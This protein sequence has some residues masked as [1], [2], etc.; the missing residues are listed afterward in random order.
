MKHKASKNPSLNDPRN[1][2]LNTVLEVLKPGRD[3][4]MVLDRSLDPALA[5]RDRALITELVYGYLRYKGRLDYV[6]ESFLKSPGKLPGGLKILMGLAAYEIYFLDRIPDYAA[7][8]RAVAL[9][10]KR[11]GS[12]MSS[13]VNAVLR[14]CPGVDAFDPDF[15]RRDKPGDIIFLSR[16]YSS[17]EWIVQMWRKDYGADIARKYLKQSLQKPATGIRLAPGADAG[18]LDASYVVQR[19]GPSVLVRDHYPGLEDLEREKKVFRQSFAGQKTLWELGLGAWRSPVWD[20]CA[21][22]G[23]KTM[24][25]SSQGMQVWAS[26]TYLP[27]LAGLKKGFLEQGK[28]LVFAAQ[29]QKPP[30]KKTPSTVLVDAPCTGLGVLSRRP[31]SKWK[32]SPQDVLDLSHVQKG[33]FASAAGILLRDSELIYVTCTLSR[34]ENQEQVADFLDTHQD[35]ECVQTYDT[36]LDENLGEF[37]FGVRLRRR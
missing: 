13:L 34:Q 25:M 8:S 9:A 23:G 37:F 32:R 7:V 19:M 14:K 33:L 21:G 1:I 36:G 24:L 35:F 3:L 2:A 10:R 11:F 28:T 30:L 16:F 15:Y 29:G 22:R 27:R 12:R 4:Q 31:D 18:S 6:L 17:P 20:M 5:P 26:D